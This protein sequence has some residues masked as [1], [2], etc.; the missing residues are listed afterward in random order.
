MDFSKNDPNSTSR[1]NYLMIYSNW[2]FHR[3]Y[4]MNSGS[5]AGSCCALLPQ[6]A[7]D[8]SVKQENI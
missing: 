5:I 2:I 1:Q 8:I 6:A 4:P 7:V 3:K